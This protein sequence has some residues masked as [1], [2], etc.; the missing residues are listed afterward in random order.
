MLRNRGRKVERGTEVGQGTSWPAAELGGPRSPCCVH[1]MTGGR[2]ERP[3]G[4]CRKTG[5][6][7]MP[8]KGPGTDVGLLVRGDQ[9]EPRAGVEGSRSESRQVRW[10]LTAT[11]AFAPRQAGA[12]MRAQEGAGGKS[13]PPNGAVG[14]LPAPRTC[15]PGTRSMKVTPGTVARSPGTQPCWRSARTSSP[16]RERELLC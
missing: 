8:C 7:C 1:T 2:G 6:R 9:G 10:D 14:A 13:P 16:T 5:R 11:E 4:C 3:G 15:P 12:D